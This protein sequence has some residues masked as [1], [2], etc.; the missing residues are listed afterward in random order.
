MRSRNRIPDMRNKRIADNCA[1]DSASYA[2]GTSASVRSVTN[3]PGKNSRISNHCQVKPS[4][5]GRTTNRDVSEQ[6]VN[7]MMGEVPAPETSLVSSYQDNGQC[8]TNNNIINDPPLS[9]TFISSTNL[10]V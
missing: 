10:I 5:S 9:Q 7:L 2:V 1:V 3:L 6:V 8:P 4:F